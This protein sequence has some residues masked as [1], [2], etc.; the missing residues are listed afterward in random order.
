MRFPVSKCTEPTHLGTQV[1]AYQCL[2]FLVM[3]LAISA[4]LFLISD[5]NIKALRFVKT[6]FLGL[7]LSIFMFW[8][9]P[10]FLVLYS[11]LWNLKESKMKGICN[12]G[13]PVKLLSSTTI[14][15]ILLME[16][17]LF[18][19]LDDTYISTYLKPFLT[20][21]PLP[22][23]LSA[24][25]VSKSVL[26]KRHVGQLPFKTGVYSQSRRIYRP[27]KYIWTASTLSTH[28]ITQITAQ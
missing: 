11:W 28:K 3:L 24:C 17:C 15:T 8:N 10:K 23:S 22:R 1:V 2:D 27:R 7:I 16:D 9:K 6:V 18:H 20:R 14:Q 21:K 13:L 25:V 4:S 19:I 5:W 26:G 12:L